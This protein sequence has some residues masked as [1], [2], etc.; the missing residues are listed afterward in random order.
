L[1]LFIFFVDV[2][3]VVERRHVNVCPRVLVVVV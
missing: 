2:V 1:K 3:P